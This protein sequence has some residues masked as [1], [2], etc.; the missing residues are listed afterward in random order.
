[1]KK[2]LTKSNMN[3]TLSTPTQEVVILELQN[4]YKVVDILMRQWSD[5][6]DEYHKNK[7]L[8]KCIKRVLK[9]YGSSPTK[10]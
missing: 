8:L 3:F 7:K 6:N 10:L 2:L 9:Y 1:M 4:N 5:S